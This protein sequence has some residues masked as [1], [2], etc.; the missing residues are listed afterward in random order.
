[1]TED[2]DD[3]E[4]TEHYDPVSPTPPLRAPPRRSTAPQSEFTTGQ[5]GFGFLVLA[6]GLGV[7]FG[8]PLLLA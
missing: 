3:G 6:I 7:T 1:M 2:H 5:V 4:E 8:L